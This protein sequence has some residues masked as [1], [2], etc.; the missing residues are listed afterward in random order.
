MLRT[1]GLADHR[2]PGRDVRQP[3]RGFGL[4]DVLAAGAT[5]AHG[6]GAHVGFLDVDLDAVVDHGEDRDRRK[7]RMPSRVGIER[8][9]PHQPVYAGFGLEPAIGVVTA[10]LDGG[11]FDAG[12]FTLGFFQIFDLETVLFRPAR[13]HAQ[14]HRGPVLALGSAGPG[15]DLEIGIEP[16]GLAAEQ[17]LEFA[18][19]NF[20][21]QRL[22]RGLGLGDNAFVVLGFAEL[23][24][25]DI[26][27]E[28]ALDLADA[29]E[30]I[31]Q[32]GSLLHQFLGLLGI[33]PEIGIFSELVQLRQARR[34]CIDVK[35]ASSA[36][37]PTA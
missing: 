7:R 34:G 20:L 10:D 23:D 30:R 35:D 4:V 31:L 3:H 37:R 17:R 12:L 16:V 15:M 24:H 8:R 29:G 9:Y 13:V 25:A 2:D 28:F 6:V 19:G 5:R 26:V 22:Q 1:S 14:Q 21:F 18:A 36:A 33:V 11:G 27:L 32:R